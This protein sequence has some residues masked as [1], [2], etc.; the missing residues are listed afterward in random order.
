M[1]YANAVALEL[2]ERTVEDLLGAVFW[3]VFPEAYDHEFGV[4]YRKAMATRV[5]QHLEA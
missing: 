1:Q 2:V 4:A 5:E 3:D